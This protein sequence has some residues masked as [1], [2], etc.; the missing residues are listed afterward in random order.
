MR[1]VIEEAAIWWWETKFSVKHQGKDI[2]NPPSRND[3]PRSTLCPSLS[4]SF[5]ISFY[6]PVTMHLFFKD[7]YKMLRVFSE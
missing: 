6:I 7:K 5:T 3:L 2:H 1:L 4:L